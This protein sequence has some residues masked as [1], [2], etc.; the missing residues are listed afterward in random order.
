MSTLSLSA[1]ARRAIA[2]SRGVALAQTAKR[3]GKPEIPVQI[4]VSA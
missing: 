4:Q 2:G 3:Q 1:L